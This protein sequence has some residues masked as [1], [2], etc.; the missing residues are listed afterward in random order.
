[1]LIELSLP[2]HFAYISS[3]KT[4]RGEEKE[5]SLIREWDRSTFFFELH[6]C[7]EERKCISPWLNGVVSWSCWRE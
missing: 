3:L 1:V 4:D 5:I 6:L 2:P 7:E